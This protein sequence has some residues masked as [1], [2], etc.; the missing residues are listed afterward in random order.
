MPP[1]MERHPRP[2]QRHDTAGGQRN[3]R[4]PP[5]VHLARGATALDAEAD[6]A[7]GPDIGAAGT[8]PPGASHRAL[9]TPGAPLLPSVV[10]ELA[11]LRG[12]GGTLPAALRSRHEGRLGHDVSRVRIHDGK[13]AA[14][15]SA[16]LGAEA[17]T[18]GRD[19]V[20]GRPLD[21]ADRTGLL[22]HELAHV[23]QLDGRDGLVL[24]RP[25][26]GAT[27]AAVATAEDRREFVQAA[28]RFLES[29]SDYYAQVTAPPPVERVLRQWQQIV[30]A[31][32]RTV[33]DDLGADPALY[34]ALRAA[35]RHALA[36]L[37]ESAARLEHRP[38]A[39][40]YEQHRSI[41]PEWA[42]PVQ[43]VP[44]TTAELPTEATIGA[45]RRA[46]VTVGDVQVIV[47]PD[48]FVRAGSTKTT[49]VF[50]RY[51]IDYRADSNGRVTSYRGPARPVVTV[52]TV[53]GRGER[54][55]VP[56][57]YGRGT[58]PEDVAAGTTT[59]G[60]HEASHAR[61]ILRFLREHPYPQFTG[62]VGMSTHD[63]DTAMAD[64]GREVAQYTD[65]LTA[66]TLHRTDCV[67]TTIDQ[68]GAEGGVGVRIQCSP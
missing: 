52:R 6:R 27:T 8:F 4:I 28:I 31:H 22:A 44:G 21:S 38:A 63:F 49:F 34:Q 60:F 64:Y 43:R 3:G 17:F 14:G 11:A 33:I 15:L 37:V 61:D 35:Y 30:E 56:S 23:V 16:R 25:R 20:L 12:T 32:G 51:R 1:S 48:S 54:P 46:S 65:R 62:T 42:F 19:V 36:A 5:T 57:A 41:I 18:V 39:A 9:L 29:T 40:L 24:R 58:T 53:Y 26:P 66:D 55:D 47:L 50:K 10:S 13:R 68:H 45:R 59:L 67:G 2:A 7:A